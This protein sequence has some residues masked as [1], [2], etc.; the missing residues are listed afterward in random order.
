[1]SINEEIRFNQPRL[2]LVE[3]VDDRFFFSRLIQERELPYFKVLHSGLKD[4]RQGGNSLFGK[5][6]ST[7]KLLPSFNAVAH[8]VIV[9]DADNSAGDQFE[10]VRH[11][12]DTRGHNPPTQPYQR[13]DQ[14]PTLEIVVVPLH[15]DRGNLE[16]V[17]IE[18]ATSARPNL[19]PHIANFAAATHADQWE[20]ERR[21]KMWLRSYLAA[22][23]RRDP[24]VPLGDVFSRPNYREL[25][26]FQHASLNPL[27]EILESY[28]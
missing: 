8:V 19:P 11:S 14:R 15:E 25:I 5:A 17:C 16:S 26:D 1:L 28:R 18:P 13:T 2:L 22:G 9:T 23:C 20:P 27:A 12:L 3:G 7:L 21:A 4:S 6:L 24:F 10:F